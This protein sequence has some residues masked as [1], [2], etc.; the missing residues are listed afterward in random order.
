MA[1]QNSPECKEV[2]VQTQCETTA[3]EITSRLT[4]FGNNSL[5]QYEQMLPIWTNGAPSVD[6][7]AIHCHKYSPGS[8]CGVKM[9]GETKFTVSTQGGSFEWKGVGIR[10]YVG[11]GSLPASVNECRINIRASFSGQFQLPED[12]ALSSGSQLPASSHSL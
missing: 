1:V 12:S 5:H 7:Y 3:A 2:A 4:A 11:K 8:I 6:L 10:I 9:I